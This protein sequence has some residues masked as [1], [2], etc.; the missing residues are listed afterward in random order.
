MRKTRGA[1]RMPSATSIPHE[2]EVHGDIERTSMP[3]IGA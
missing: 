1:Q 3:A 2:D